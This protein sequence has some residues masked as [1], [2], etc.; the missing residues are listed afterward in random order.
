MN[1]AIVI[2]AGVMMLSAL[3]YYVS[4]HHE[5]TGPVKTCEGRQEE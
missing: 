3:H 4:A 1:F 5:Y 2:F